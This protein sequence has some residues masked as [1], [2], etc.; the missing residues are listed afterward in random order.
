[1]PSLLPLVSDREEILVPKAREEAPSGQEISTENEPD[2]I[3]PK[4]QGL[5]EAGSCAASQDSWYH[6]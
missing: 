4:S 1:M 2:V 3:G 5:D 6:N